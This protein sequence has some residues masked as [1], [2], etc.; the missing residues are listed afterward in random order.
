MLLWIV[1]PYRRL[2]GIIHIIASP[3]IGPLVCYFYLKQNTTDPFLYIWVFLMF[4]AAFIIAIAIEGFVFWINRARK[5]SIAETR[6]GE[7]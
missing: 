4:P 2:N 1:P 7:T 5:S 3:I 6:E